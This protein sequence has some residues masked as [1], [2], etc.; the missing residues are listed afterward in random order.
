MSNITLRET[1]AAPMD[2]NAIGA[3]LM[4]RYISYI[5]ASEK[6]VQSY[7]TALKQFFKWIADRG[8]TQPT[9]ED[10]I[11]YRDSIAENH[12]PTTVQSYLVAVKLFFKWTEQEGI[13]PDIAEHIKSV[14]IDKEH[15]KD[16]LSTNQARA[17]LEIIDTSSLTGKRDFAIIRL[18][19]T[20]GLRTIEVARANIEDLKILG[21]ST[22]LF[23]Q[24][25]GH[26]EKAQY[27]KI[28]YETERAIM[29]YLK[30][31][32]NAQPKEALFASTSNNN[33][34]AGM[35]TRSIRSIVKENL[36]KIGLDSDRLTA[37]SLRHTAVTI[38]LMAGQDI[39]EV[40]QFARHSNINTTM[41]YNHSLEIARN[42]CAQTIEAALKV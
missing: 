26:A 35:T 16:P 36:R 13:Y 15:K 20:G 10:V 22:V 3:D 34:G 17:L 30:A 37:H 23:V 27:V 38:S 25:K 8:I 4:N 6:T 12:K 21:D 31:R 33:R 39:T 42:Q 41:I 14:K 7:K 18:M 1:A 9:R 28:T 29:E 24:G 5:D 2:Y 19:L 40:Q 32:G 11:F